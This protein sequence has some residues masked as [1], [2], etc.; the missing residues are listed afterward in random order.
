MDQVGSSNATATEEIK[1]A[2]WYLFD[3]AYTR[4]LHHIILLVA[5]SIL[6]DE[7]IEGRGETHTWWVT[8]FS[9][10]ISYSYTTIMNYN[11]MI[12]LHL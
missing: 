2:E 4:V 1:T 6:Y 9:G 11:K 3:G 10:D 5:T 8:T 12:E 7:R